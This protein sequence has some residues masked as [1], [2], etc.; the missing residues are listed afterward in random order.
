[1]SAQLPAITP[2]DV[3]GGASIFQFEAAVNSLINQ[4]IVDISISGDNLIKF[5]TADL[6]EVVVPIPGASAGIISGLE[7]TR[8]GDLA[9]D[10]DI[11]SAQMY[12]GIEVLSSP[13]SISI[14]ARHATLPR[15][16]IVVFD[17]AHMSLI[18]TVS[19]TAATDPQLPAISA[20][21]GALYFVWVDPA[22]VAV[23]IEILLGSNS[24]RPM[25]FD[26]LSRFDSGV[27]E[28]DWSTKFNKPQ[29]FAEQSF[30]TGGTLDPDLPRI[31]TDSSGGI[32][33]IQ[34]GIDPAEIANYEGMEWVFQDQGSAT[35]SA[36]TIDGSGIN[37]NGAATFDISADY[38][39]VT[40][41]VKGGVYYVG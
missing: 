8:T 1:M 35:T 23:P 10:I 26:Q 29:R 33:T 22:S 6:S 30:A 16:D 3:S 36:V 40:V 2:I 9:W 31:Y 11:G 24:V 21:Q 15:I 7:A 28:F 12:G 17:P 38:L 34:M 25:N 13:V 37:I 32:F 14:N 18:T 27:V 4:R 39:R 41:S 20:T 19:G 5:I